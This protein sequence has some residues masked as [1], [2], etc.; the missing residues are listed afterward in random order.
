MGRI[1][2]GSTKKERRIKQRG[3]AKSDGA[4]GES[5]DKANAS[6]VHSEN[7][8]L[9]GEQQSA[10]TLVSGLAAAHIHSSPKT[11]TPVALP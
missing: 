1:S 8:E 10:S 4:N 11:L 7:G 3:N 5:K 2:Q 9:G 6:T